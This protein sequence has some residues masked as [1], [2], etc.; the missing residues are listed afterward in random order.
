MQQSESKIALLVDGDNA[1][2][3]KIDAILS[4]I[5]KYGVVDIYG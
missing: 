5:A 3:S 4:E 2:A 1:P